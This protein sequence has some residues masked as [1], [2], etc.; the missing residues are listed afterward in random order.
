MKTDNELI[1]EFMGFKHRKEAGPLSGELYDMVKLTKDANWNVAH[2]HKSWD[3]LMPVVE[4]INGLRE[5]GDFNAIPRRRMYGLSIFNTLP[6]V[7][8]HVVDFIKWY[9]ESAR[10]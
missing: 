5:F 8:E 9:N 1:A 6:T 2:W 10:V 3:W 4:K 7:Y